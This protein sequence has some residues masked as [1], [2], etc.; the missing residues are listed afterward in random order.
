[1]TLDFTTITKPMMDEN[2]ISMSSARSTPL[3]ALGLEAEER[4]R[5]ER[6]GVT[7][8]A[9]LNRL[10]AATGVSAAAR[11]ADLPVARLRSALL[12]GQ[13]RVTGI[14]GVAQPPRAVAPPRPTP[15]QPAPPRPAATPPASPRAPVPAN[16]VPRQ[17][18]RQP[19]PHLPIRTV[20]I[21]APRRA[22][23]A[24]A[25]ADN[26]IRLPYG[27]RGVTVHG[28]HFLSGEELP[29]VRLDGRE[30]AIEEA[31]DDRLVLR[32]PPD[33][34]PGALEI[35]LG[36]GETLTFDLDFTSEHDDPWA[37]PV[38]HVR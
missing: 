28:A 20:P 5:L 38:E 30:L 12:Q 24:M 18:V 32:L 27:A 37:P 34:A 19:E 14:G 2:T 15:T 10:G 29:S 3:E 36:D 31:D 25:A 16:L 13:P 9:Q 8:L 4:Q 17:A 23:V 7:T 21:L 33:A 35:S 6:L 26:V 1:M 22:P 11:L